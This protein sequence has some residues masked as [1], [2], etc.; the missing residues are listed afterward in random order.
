MS[1]ISV[2]SE[3]LEQPESQ[4]PPPK[5]PVS[6]WR[7]LKR[8][9]WTLMS[10]LIILMLTLLWLTKTESGLR[11]TLFRIPA[12]FGV[13]ITADKVSGS[14]LNG[15][16]GENWVVKTE[17]ANINL[18]NL[19]IDWASSELL[20][21]TIHVRKIDIG[22]MHIDVMAAEP[23]P[24]Q[25]STFPQSLRLPANVHLDEI[26]IAKITMGKNHDVILNQAKLNYHYQHGQAHKVV[27][28]K[29]D[30]TFGIADGHIAL[31]ES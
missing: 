20:S 15:F 18:R 1:Q 31:G 26:N 21:R 5:K 19:D 29:L 14:V 4:T 30:S 24:D 22:E 11:F 7:W 2:T 6:K 16:K 27:I 28:D 10:V 25:E 3:T 23:R 9:V 8:L 12:W 13:E 17:G